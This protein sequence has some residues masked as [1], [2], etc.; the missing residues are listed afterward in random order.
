LRINLTVVND[1][2]FR[3]PP[4]RNDGYFHCFVEDHEV[5]CVDQVDAEGRLPILQMQKENVK[6]QMIE[7]GK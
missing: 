5:D 4:V 3:K 6:D 1:I 7:D 2:S